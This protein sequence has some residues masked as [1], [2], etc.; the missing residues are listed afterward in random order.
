M[1]KIEAIDIEISGLRA[2]NPGGKFNNSQINSLTNLKWDIEDEL[3]PVNFDINEVTK[4]II[5]RKKQ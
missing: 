3:I 2:N 1:I 5:N 4:V